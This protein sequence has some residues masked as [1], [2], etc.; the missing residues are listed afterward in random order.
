MSLEYDTG[1]I[2]IT[3]MCGQYFNV[4][5]NLNST[6]LIVDIQGKTTLDSGPHQKYYGLTSYTQGWSRTYGG[7]NDETVSAL[8]RT[9]D[10]GYALAGYTYSFGA[11]QSDAWLVKTD[12]LGNMEW[13]MTYGGSSYDFAYA[14]VQTTD[15]GYALAGATTSFGGYDAWLVKTDENGNMQWNKTYGGPYREDAY[16]L[17][18][19]GDGG[20]A[21]AGF[22]GSGGNA[23][24]VKTDVSGNMQWNKTY[25]GQSYSLVYALVQTG[26]G[27]YALAG[28]IGNGYTDFWLVKTDSSG[29]M[30]WNRTYG[31]TN[32][33]EATT[34]V[35]TRDGGYAL[36][37]WTNSF[38]AG[39]DDFWLVKTDAGGSMQ[40]NKH[41]EAQTGRMR[42][43]WCR[44]VMMDT[45]SQVSQVMLGW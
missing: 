42:M 6:D 5:H 38:G 27:G 36:A 29:N 43:R 35:Q 33:D 7:P 45:R 22:T 18:Q 39:S 37:G 34:L 28:A 8:V 3:D 30:Q 19:T 15:G 13:N 20:Y 12:G 14:L 32:D 1:W 16:A 17:V 24:L 25:G 2:N 9:T 21:L 11:G 10:G 26:D 41:T 4:T 23:W 31:G 40:W 44:R